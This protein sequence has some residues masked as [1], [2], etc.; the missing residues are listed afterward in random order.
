MTGLDMCKVCTEAVHSVEWYMCAKTTERRK[1]SIF[2]H[3]ANSSG[4]KTR[5]TKANTSKEHAKK[6]QS[7]KKAEKK[8]QK[9]QKKS[10]KKAKEK[11][12]QKKEKNAS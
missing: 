8:Q 3:V 2:L 11:Q 7:A 10:P 4:S 6:K 9:K 12:K 5:K 1:N